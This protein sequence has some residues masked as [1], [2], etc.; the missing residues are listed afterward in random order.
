MRLLIAFL[1]VI[2]PTFAQAAIVV[3]G[4]NIE[5]APETGGPGNPKPNYRL[6]VDQFPTGDITSVWLSIQPLS[7]TQFTLQFTGGNVDDG[8]AWYLVSNGESF[9]RAGIAKNTYQRLYGDYPMPS[10]PSVIVG[11][12][13]YLGVN[14]GVSFDED[15]D[16][17]DALGWVKLRVEGR[18]SDPDLPPPFRFNLAMVDNVMS[19]YSPGIVVGTT[20]VVPEPTAIA[21][22][23]IAVLG[24]ASL[25]RRK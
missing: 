9:T 24:L 3:S 21:L 12:D 4:T 20:T 8:S 16:A 17:R 6:T 10:W 18:P 7:T 11:N 15:G 19:Y 25:R 1:V 5:L 14:T 23:G 22:C 13:F 2:A